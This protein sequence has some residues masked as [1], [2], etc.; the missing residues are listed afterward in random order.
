MSGTT[1]NASASVTFTAAT[2]SLGN[3]GGKFEHSQIITDA[4]ISPTDK[5]MVS[6]APALDSDE[7]S[8]EMLSLDTLTATAGSGNLTVLACFREKTSGNVKINYMRG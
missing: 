5:I 2:L 7:N 8:P 3:G 4:G 6:L 1:I